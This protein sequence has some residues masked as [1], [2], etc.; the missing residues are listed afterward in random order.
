M[1]RAF[2]L[3]GVGTVVTGTVHAGRVA[4]GDELQLVP[5]TA[6]ARVRSL[7]A[8]NQAVTQAQAGQR[9]A[10]AL[11]GLGKDQVT[12]GQWLVAPAV[13][14]QTSR[15]DVQLTLWQGESR[16]L[17]AAARRCTCTAGRPT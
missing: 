12:R 13:A 14:L 7:H 5:G 1:D 10:V 9:T 8:Q 6:R 17:C 2:T 15:L 3:D 11:V 4:V 16:G